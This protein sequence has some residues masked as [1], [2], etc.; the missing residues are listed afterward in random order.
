MSVYDSDESGSGLRRTITPLQ[1]GIAIGVFVLMLIGG[2]FLLQRTARPPRAAAAPQA[3]PAVVQ[4]DATGA[5]AP[6]EVQPR[7]GGYRTHQDALNQEKIENMK[8]GAM[9][10]Q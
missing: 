5:A 10:S 3:M 1:A 2:Y 7:P 9:S 6:D 4:E 8:R